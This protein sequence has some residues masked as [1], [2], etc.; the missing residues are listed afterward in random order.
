MSLLLQVSPTFAQVASNPVPATELLSQ[1]DTLAKELFGRAKGSAA[2]APEAIGFYSRGCLAG[3]QSLAS[4]GRHW[5]AMRPS[6]NRNWGHPELIGF[7]ERFAPAAASASGWPGI[8]VGDL[9]QPRGGPMLTG[10]ASH[11]LGLDADIWLKPMPLHRM[12][13][14]EREE[15]SSIKV[16][17]TDRLDIDPTTWTSAHQSVL[18]TAALDPKVQRVFVNA[19]IKRAMCRTAKGE[20]WLQKIRPEQGH[21]YH[22]HVRLLCPDG[23]GKCSPQEPT[24]EGDGCDH[25]LDAWF[26]E[27][28]LHPRPPLLPPTPLT[29]VQLPPECRAVLDAGDAAHR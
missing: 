24:P 4:D 3:A 6:R 18:R 23:A 15:A 1:H 14:T 28:A 26:T 12:T 27:E 13:N 8:L 19:A 25:T 22:F 17:R 9:A 2:L 29:L 10:H 16:V 20:P 7:I 5:Q 21:D 11:Q